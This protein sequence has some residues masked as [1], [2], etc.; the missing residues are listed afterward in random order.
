MKHPFTTLCSGKLPARFGELPARLGLSRISLR[1]DRIPV[2][3]RRAYFLNH[4]TERTAGM[5]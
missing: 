2:S 1:E 5:K 3:V 4:L